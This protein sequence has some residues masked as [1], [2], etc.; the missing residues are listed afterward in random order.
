LG[1]AIL[2]LV[3]F[4][5]PAACEESPEDMG[6]TLVGATG[7]V[8][9]N[10]E[11]FFGSTMD[12]SFWPTRHTVWVIQPEHGYKY[13]GS[14]AAIWGLGT[15]MNEMGFGYTGAAVSSVEAKDP[16]SDITMFNLGPILLESCATV[17]EAIEALEK[18]TFG[19]Q[20]WTRNWILG[21]AEGNLALVEISYQTMN[22]E[23]LTK[24]GYVVRTN[25][26]TSD[27]MKSLDKR[28]DPYFCE[29]LEAGIQ[30]FEEEHKYTRIQVGEM[31]QWLAYIYQSRQDNPSSGPGNCMVA[32][33]KART[34]WFT[35]GWP[36]GN[37]PPTELKDRQICQ[38]MTWGVPIPFYL[39]EL[40]PG[41]YTT[42][43]GQLTPLA[44]QYVMS[45]FSLDLQQSPAWYKYQSVD[46]LKPFYKPAEDVAS[47][48]GYAPKPNPYGPGGRLGT[49]TR[50]DGFVPFESEE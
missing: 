5:L 48:D 9:A 45:H 33:P 37:L 46:R 31:F 13:I 39:P 4:G 22:V 26:W 6:C 29:R 15:G 3:V 14:K 50:D 28:E 8:V 49:L 11:M 25:H 21:D 7:S 10:D 40:P 19:E 16:E 30:W 17:P 43:L 18:M 12:N 36:G 44:M 35:Y 27:V 47:P 32:Q 38:D 34:Y 2:G 42:E 41:Q 20:F 23:T 1:L 24:D